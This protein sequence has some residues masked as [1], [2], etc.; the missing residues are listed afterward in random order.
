MTD[1]QLIREVALVWVAGGGD[2]EGLTW[3]MA[4][5]QAAVLD[6][7]AAMTVKEVPND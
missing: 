5:L 3:C 6:E 1:E 4:R 2:A 7:I